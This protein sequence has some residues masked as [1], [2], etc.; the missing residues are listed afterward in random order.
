MAFIEKNLTRQAVSNIAEIIY[1]VGAA[2]TAIIKDIHMC[3]NSN[4]DCHASLWLVPSGQN[5]S[6]ENVM[7]KE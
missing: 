2:T 7:F 1:T 3:N 5:N 4:T 6:N